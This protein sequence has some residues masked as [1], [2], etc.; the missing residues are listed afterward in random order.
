[1]LYV[2]DRIAMIRLRIRI[3]KMITPTSRYDLPKLS[4]AGFSS[5]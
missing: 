3:V 2:L 1:M 5:I 4:K